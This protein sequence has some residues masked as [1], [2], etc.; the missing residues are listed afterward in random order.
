MDQIARELEEKMKF[1]AELES[2]VISLSNKFKYC[3]DNLEQSK[4][5]SAELSND[6]CKLH[7]FNDRLKREVKSMENEIPMIRKRIVDMK[8]EIFNLDKSTKDL[9]YNI[10]REDSEVVFLKE[11]SLRLTDKVNNL[12]NEKKNLR[13]AIVLM[14]KQND[15]LKEK[16]IKKD[17]KTLDFKNDISLLIERGKHNY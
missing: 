1:N 3:K 8:K 12:H 9:R 10:Y 13:T 7:H 2:S 11:E 16:V 15:H 14:K 17:A 5:I 4:A 6:N